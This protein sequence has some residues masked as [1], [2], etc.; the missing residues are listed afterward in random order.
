MT[1][2]FD[3]DGPDHF[4]AGTIGPP[5]QR[6]F[7][8]QA[9]QA[10]SLVT[11]KSEKEQVRALGEYLGELLDRVPDAGEPR[12][13]NLALIEPVQEAWAVGTVGVGY[14]EASRRV[15]VVFTGVV[16][17]EGDEAPSARF[18]VTRAQAAA[19]VDR[20]RELVRAGRPIC[21][22]CAN[23][24]DPGGHVCPRSNG[25]VVSQA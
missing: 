17:E 21:P 3:F 20:A 9:R 4:T 2:S 18:A 6:V 7:Y 5:G 8:V 22:M 15:V 19:F 14:D 1:D 11:L 16:E 13:T 24:I 10:R 12:P 23:A 25:H